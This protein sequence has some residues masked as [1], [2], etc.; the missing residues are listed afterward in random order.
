M[1][2]YFFHA[3]D[4]D[5]DDEGVVLQD[6]AAARREAIRATG[7]MISDMCDH[8]QM[9]DSWTMLVVDDVG[10]RVCELRFSTRL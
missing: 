10:G 4:A 9:G 3:S 1:C 6:D 2:R 7:Q 8:H 5:Q